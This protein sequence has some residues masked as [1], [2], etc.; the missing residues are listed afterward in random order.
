MRAI[1]IFLILLLL[2]VCASA[3]VASDA[4]TSA[5]PFL[6]MPVG[7]RYIAMGGAATAVA[8]DSTA[9][10]YNPAL[11]AQQ[12]W[13]SIDF[14][15]SVYFEDTSY[16]YLSMSIKLNKV[17]SLG[18]S[19]QYFSY[20]DLERIDY[21]GARVGSFS[22]SDLALAIGYAHNIKGFG[23]GVN[24]KYVQS[25]IINTANTFA[26]DFGITSPEIY[27]NFFYE[28]DY[29]DSLIL[30]VVVKNVG[31][32]IKYNNESE[33]L[34]LIMALGAGYY[35]SNYLFSL[36]AGMYE[37]EA[38]FALG[39]EY[40]LTIADSLNALFRAGYNTISNPAFSDVDGLTG[41]SC[42]LGVKWNE[43]SFDYA[44]VPFG[45]LGNTHRFSLSYSFGYL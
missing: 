42:G 34:P 18:I 4:G 19:A 40:D 10:F 25:T 12:Y 35:V 31:G 9:M 2:N 21:N 45:D 39:C 15:H 23:A 27:T 7:A 41:F 17:S 32:E 33:P 37:G 5:V 8:E 36:D 22:P 1:K 16:D 30:G 26:F 44:F 28:Q 11:L 14:M 3:L 38:Y 6:N 24:V 29:N 20:G 43:V 13:N